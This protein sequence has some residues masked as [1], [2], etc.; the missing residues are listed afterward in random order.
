MHPALL[1][2]LVSFI[3]HAITWLGRDLLQEFF[4]NIYVRVVN[5][6]ASSKLSTKKKELYEMRQQLNMTSA[7]DEFSKWA[8]LRRKVDKLTQ[9]VD[10]QNKTMAS[11]QFMFS[12]MFKGFM[13]VLNS[14]I[15]FILNW[16]FKR[17]PMFYLPPG[18]WFGP[19]GP[20]FSFPNAPA[21][22]VSSTVWTTVCG[23]VL[24]LIGAYGRELFVREPMPQLEAPYESAPKASG[25]KHQEE[26]DAVPQPVPSAGSGAEKS[27]LK[28]RHTKQAS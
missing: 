24:A 4:R 19:L 16:Y 14:A 21:G 12:I 13:F 23:R 18:D 3:N 22:A 9:E 26:K 20:L 27:T 1:I 2:F 6:S 8:R 10:E 11:S 7:Q 17:V 25:L 15:P 5:F 28:H